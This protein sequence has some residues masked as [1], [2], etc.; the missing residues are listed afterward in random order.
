MHLANFLPLEEGERVVTLI[1]LRDF[2]E[3]RYLFLATAKG[4]VKKMDLLE[5]LSVT[6][7][8]TKAI[9]LGEGD[10]L[11]VAFV[12][13]GSDEVLLATARGFGLA[14]REE[15]IRPMG[16][17]A[18]G[19]RGMHLREG[20][21]VVGACPLK[22]E[23]TLLIVTS[24]GMGKRMSLSDFPVHHR[25]G[26]GVRILKSFEHTGE[27]V[28][29]AAVKGEEELLLS[30]QNGLLLRVHTG[31]IPVQGRVTRGVR[32]ISLKSQDKVAAFAVTPS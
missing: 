12:T 23:A 25:G 17:G 32:L 24:L 30:T 8:G 6:R 2:K 1:P 20:D 13:K 9:G 22:R 7:R 18:S 28:G 3:G 11:E 15:E 29:I 4:K 16:R 26:M 31:E 21:R 14:F 5:F 10:E 19:V 27:I